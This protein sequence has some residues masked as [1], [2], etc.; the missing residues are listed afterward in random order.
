ME[1]LDRHPMPRKG[2]PQHT[3][4]LM[5]CRG[6][7]KTTWLCQYLDNTKGLYQSVYYL[8]PSVSHDPKTTAALTRFA[9]VQ[10]RDGPKRHREAPSIHLISNPEQW[11]EIVT[12]L[13]QRTAEQSRHRSL[14]VMDDVGWYTK[15]LRGSQGLQAIFFNSRHVQVDIVMALQH[16]KSVTPALRSN[17]TRLLLWASPNRTQIKLLAEEFPIR[18]ADGRLLSNNEWLERY[19]KITSKRYQFM[20]LAAS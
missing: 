4:L 1:H 6:S 5:A 3:T 13:S 2:D 12:A 17:A 15:W 16:W 14:L 19:D 11:D 8:S 20:V 7:G 9:R 10:Y 18:S